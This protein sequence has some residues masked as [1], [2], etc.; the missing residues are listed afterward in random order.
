MTQVIL[1]LEL[2][3]LL[4]QYGSFEQIPTT[5]S[6]PFNKWLAFLKRTHST[7]QPTFPNVSDEGLLPFFRLVATK[8]IPDTALQQLQTLPGVEGAYDKPDDEPPGLP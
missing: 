5:V 3:R 4:H 7:L 6:L 8:E 1:T 2:A